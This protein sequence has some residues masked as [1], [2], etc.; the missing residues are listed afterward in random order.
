MMRAFL[1]FLALLSQAAASKLKQAHQATPSWSYATLE[2][3]CTSTYPYQ[4]PINLAPPFVPIGNH[5]V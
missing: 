4:S 3:V 2:Q 5:N 1:T